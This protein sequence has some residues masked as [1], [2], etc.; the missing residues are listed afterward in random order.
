MQVSTETDAQWL[1]VEA[2]LLTV[3]VILNIVLNGWE[4]LQMEVEM[5]KRM[6]HVLR[7][8]VYVRDEGINWT[9]ENF[10]HLHTPLSASATLQWTF[11]DGKKVNCPWALLVEGDVILLKHV[12]GTI[13]VH[14]FVR[15]FRLKE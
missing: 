8:L 15:V 4:G 3:L 1:I 10:P 5:R 2:A 6:E 7:Q 12:L 13:I 9:M 11:R 14:K